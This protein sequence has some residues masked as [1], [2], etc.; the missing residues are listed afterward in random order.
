MAFALGLVALYSWPLIHMQTPT[1]AQTPQKSDQSPLLPPPPLCFV[2]SMLGKEKGHISE[3]SL[4]CLSPFNS[5]QVWWWFSSPGLSI[6]P[7]IQKRR[8]G[9]AWRREEGAGPSLI[10]QY[11]KL[12]FR[13]RPCLH[14]HYVPRQGEMHP[15]IFTKK[16]WELILRHAITPKRWPFGHIQATWRSPLGRGSQS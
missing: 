14:L 11:R 12:S 16:G 5:T 6:F 1:A 10:E 2:K 8:G 7:F 4:P 15:H 13:S 9:G 3:L